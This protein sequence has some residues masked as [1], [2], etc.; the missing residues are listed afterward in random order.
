MFSPQ[1]SMSPS[2]IARA[3]QRVEDLRFNPL[4]DGMPQNVGEGLATLGRALMARRLAGQINQQF[5][6]APG[7]AMQP[8]V[9]PALKRVAEALSK[10]TM[11]WQFPAAPQASAPA[12]AVSQPQPVPQPTP[13]APAQAVPTPDQNPALSMKA[14]RKNPAGFFGLFGKKAIGGGLY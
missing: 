14:V 2:E 8:N 12:Q 3:R 11:P 13:A 6:T 1:R 10:N 5:P 7:G 4:E 9:S